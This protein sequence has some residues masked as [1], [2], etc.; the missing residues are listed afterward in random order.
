MIRLLYTNAEIVALAKAAGVH[1]PA[2]LL[3]EVGYSRNGIL[4]ACL[5]CL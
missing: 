5:F 2:E 4:A 3:T 1:M